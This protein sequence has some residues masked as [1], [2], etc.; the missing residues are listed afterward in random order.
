LKRGVSTAKKTVGEILKE[1]GVIRERPKEEEAEKIEHEEEKEVDMKKIVIKLEKLSVEIAD[2]KEVKFHADERIRELSEKIGELRSMVFQRESSIKEME[3]KVKFIE[4][5]VS[6]IEPKKVSMEME[7]RKQ[8]IEEKGLK[9]ERLE[10]MNK[11]MLDKLRS[12]EKITENIKS[13]ENLK[14]VLNKVEE[15]VKREEKTKTDVDRMAGKA[16]KFYME[17]ENRVKEFPEFKIKLE[18]VDDLTKEITKTVDGLNIR[19]SAFASREDLQSFKSGVDSVIASNREKL[20]NSIKEIEKVLKLPTKEII[21]RKNELKIKRDNVS[22]LLADI[23]EQHRTG[24]VTEKSYNEVK[25]RNES[26]LKNL[27]EEI[28]KLEGEETFSLKSLPSI[29]NEL[30]TSLS[31]LEDR[32]NSLEGEDIALTLKTQTDVVKNILSKLKDVG[33]KTSNLGL[34]ISFFEILNMIMRV[35][36]VRDITFYISEL[37]KIVSEMKSNNLWDDRKESLVKG[38]LTDVGEA[39]RQYGYNDIAQVFINGINKII[40]PVS[41]IVGI[42]ETNEPENIDIY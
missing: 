40:S 37:E 12:V 1:Q 26:L 9:I 20:E 6:S 41:G 17:M 39:W 31:T 23:E 29:I 8:E 22:K 25:E 10:A 5:A 14:N 33:K 21:A 36:N 16:E 15:M 11:E 28:N 35:E 32:I 27:D 24:K 30:Q 2:L 42:E 34:K 18:K 13:M 19:L 3:S 4:D 38:L 7:K